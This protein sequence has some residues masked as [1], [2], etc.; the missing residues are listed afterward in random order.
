LRNVS[1][2]KYACPLRYYTLFRNITLGTAN[3]LLFSSNLQ[4]GGQIENT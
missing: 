3:D 1:L 2:L 4:V